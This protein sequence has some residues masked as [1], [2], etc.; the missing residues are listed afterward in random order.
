M[1]VQFIRRWE[2]AFGV[3][4]GLAAGLLILPSGLAWWLEIP[5]RIL[6]GIPVALGII[7]LLRKI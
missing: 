7:A 2:I 4:G 1:I 3:V 6:I 5:L